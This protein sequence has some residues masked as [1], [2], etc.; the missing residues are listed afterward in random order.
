MSEAPEIQARKIQI[1][2]YL[3]AMTAE[4]ILKNGIR[5]DRSGQPVEVIIP[6][7]QFIDF[8]QL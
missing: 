7:E 8:T 4:G 5:Y 1:T 6:Y 2:R 3:V